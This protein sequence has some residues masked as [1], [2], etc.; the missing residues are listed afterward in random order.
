MN[1]TLACFGIVV[2]DL[3][4]GPVATE[5]DGAELAG[6]TLAA[7]P[8]GFVPRMEIPDDCAGLDRNNGWGDEGNRA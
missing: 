5:T 1:I 8:M 2:F 3:T 6:G 7:T 4:I